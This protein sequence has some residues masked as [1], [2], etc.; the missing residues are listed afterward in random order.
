MAH[1]THFVVMGVS[2]TGKSTVAEPLARRLD[3]PF[4]EADDFHPAANVAKMSAGTAL[5]DEDRQPWLEALAAW[6]AG[7]DGRGESTLMACSALKRSYRDVLR[8]AAP[9]VRFLHLDGST[10]L[11]AARLR[12]RKGHFMPETLLRSQKST[13]E[14]LADDEP[15]VTLDIAP[16]VEEVVERAA[17]IVA[18]AL[19]CEIDSRG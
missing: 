13:L 6:I 2:G 10:E 16:P 17:R 14:P 18:A 19:G 12:E 4:A 3:L 1:G 7:H 8:A 9:D 15:G 5:T 11:I